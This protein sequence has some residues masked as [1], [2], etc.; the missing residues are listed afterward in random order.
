MYKAAYPGGFAIGAFNVNGLESI[1][2]VTAGCAAEDSPVILQA[3][4]KALAQ[5]GPKYLMKLIEAALETADLPV[6]LHLDHGEDF[7][8]CRKAIECGYTSVMVDGSRF[9]LEENIALTRRVVEYAH[10]RGIPVEAELGRIG[11]GEGVIL[12]GAAEASYTD[13]AEAERFVCESGCDSLAVAI[14]TAHGAFKFPG[15]PK[16]DFERLAEIRR[17]LPGLPLVLHGASSVPQECVA[18]ANKYGAK[19]SGARGVPEEMISRAA[20][21]GVSKVNVNTDLCIAMIGNVRKYLSENPQTCEPRDYLADGREAVK[22]LVRRK[23]RI[24]GSSGKASAMMGRPAA[25][26][27]V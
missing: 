13:P 10:P 21:M 14:G 19:F 27:A 8:I 25:A 16:L 1:Q 6:A 9:S 18:L 4:H 26:R 3:C 17:R 2:A 22:E 20:G 7:E 23:V 24:M 5:M 11:G 15:E 12:V